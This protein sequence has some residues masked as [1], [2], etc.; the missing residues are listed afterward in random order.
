MTTAE[1]T[2]QGLRTIQRNLK[3][4]P[5]GFVS[6]GTSDQ[7]VQLGVIWDDRTL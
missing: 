1:H 2:D 3:D 5:P 6:S 4:T 7:H